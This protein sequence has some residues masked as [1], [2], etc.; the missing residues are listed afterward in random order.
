MRLPNEK[1]NEKEYHHENIPGGYQT[2]ERETKADS[3]RRLNREGLP[4]EFS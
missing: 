4:T 1:V 3:G 2:Y